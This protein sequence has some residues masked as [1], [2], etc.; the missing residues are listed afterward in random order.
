MILPLPDGVKGRLFQQRHRLHDACVGDLALLVNRRFDHDV[1]LYASGLSDGR[2]ERSDL[3]DPVRRTNLTADANRLG[4]LLASGRGGLRLS[5]LFRL[6]ALAF[7]LGIGRGLI[8]GGLRRDGQFTGAVV[9][10]DEFP[11]LRLQLGVEGRLGRL[12]LLERSGGV[13]SAPAL[14]ALAID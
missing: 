13:L 7:A 3:L 5:R 12:R 4:E 9:R 1:A 11:L 10:L 14:D 6:R 8:G 2:V